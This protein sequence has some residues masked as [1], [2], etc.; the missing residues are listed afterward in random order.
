MQLGFGAALLT[1]AAGMPADSDGSSK[2]IDFLAA[3][4]KGQFQEP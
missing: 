4:N 3:L 2:Q 1:L